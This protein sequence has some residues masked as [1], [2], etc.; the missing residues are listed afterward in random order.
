MK[1]KDSTIVLLGNIL[2]YVLKWGPVALILLAIMFVAFFLRYF[3]NVATVKW[4]FEMFLTGCGLLIAFL[5][6]CGAGSAAI[7]IIKSI[8]GKDAADEANKTA[9]GLYDAGTYDLF[10]AWDAILEE[11]NRKRTAM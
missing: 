6:F 10:S 8:K 4:L 7:S 11:A 9:I 2:R 1:I 3:T 5:L